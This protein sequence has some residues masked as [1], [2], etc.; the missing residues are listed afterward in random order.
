MTSD[1]QTDSVLAL[2]AEIDRCRKALKG[3][4]PDKERRGVEGQ[5][6]RTRMEMD[7]TVARLNVEYLLR[8]VTGDVNETNRQPLLYLLAEEKA[9]LVALE[10]TIE[11]IEEEKE[12][13]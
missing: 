3:R 13:L 7:R 10:P 1:R 8:T 5:L 4:L 12:Q 11:T 2:Q 6:R 9:R